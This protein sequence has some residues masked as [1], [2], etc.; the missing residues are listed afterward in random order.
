MVFFGQKY[1]QNSQIGEMDMIYTGKSYYEEFL[2]NPRPF[3]GSTDLIQFHS[4]FKSIMKKG[5]ENKG[6]RTPCVLY[7]LNLHGSFLR[8]RDGRKI[9][10]EPNSFTVS[11]G[12]R[13]NST[14]RVVSDS[15]L[16]RKCCL[17]YRNKI[18]DMIM[19]GLGMTD[20]AVI[21]LS[22]VGAVDKIMNSIYTVMQNSNY[23][24]AHLSGMF[25]ELLQEVYSQRQ[26]HFLPEPLDKTLAYINANFSN[27]GLSCEEIARHTGVSVRHLNRLFREYMNSSII[28]YI[29]DIRLE[30]VC[31]LL[32]RSHLQINEIAEKCG[33]SSTGFM[34]RQFRRKYG[35]TPRAYRLTE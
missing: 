18:H 14:I 16:E 28:P 22:D 29:N 8:T 9:I 11:H 21:Q 23:S 3:D 2:F 17:V 6:K 33:F 32:S 34:T 35:Q 15:S 25:F 13:E 19:N 27:N 24:Q 30:H 5:F 12:L 7:S 10:V 4:Y 20:G 1:E 26:N 31:A